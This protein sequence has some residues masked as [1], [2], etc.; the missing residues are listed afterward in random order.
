MTEPTILKLPRTVIP[1]GH[2][3]A[4]F[5]IV[6]FDDTEWRFELFY[7]ETPG[8]EFHLYCPLT[9]HEV[10]ECFSSFPSYEQVQRAAEKFISTHE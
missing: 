5:F 7:F 1:D 2:R 6:E 3:I 9:P 4:D 10:V 8:A